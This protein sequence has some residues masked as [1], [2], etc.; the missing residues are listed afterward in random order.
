MRATQ[1]RHCAMAAVATAALLFTI[2]SCKLQPAGLEGGATA[3]SVAMTW[4][5]ATVYLP[6][7]FFPTTPGGIQLDRRLPVVIYLHGCTGITYTHDAAWGRF[8]K[9]LGFIAVMPDSMARPGRRSNC[10]PVYKTTGLFPQAAAMR[11]EEISYA[12]QRI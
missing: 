10:D 2:A 5:H 9:S 12:L 6:D 3:S 11:D 4:E 1:S 7:S 8:I